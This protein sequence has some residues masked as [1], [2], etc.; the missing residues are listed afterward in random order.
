MTIHRDTRTVPYTADQMFELVAGIDD[1]PDFIPWCVGMK[2]RSRRVDAEGSG[3]ILA[4]MIVGY[5][6]FR[7]RFRSK[8]R[9]DRAAKT[10]VVDYV[11]GPFRRLENRWT[12]TDLEGGGSEID[13]VIDFEFKSRL[14]QATANQVLDKAFKRLSDAFLARAKDLH[15]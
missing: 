2:V 1:Y 12:F 5:K 15:G 14:L 8:V 11:N 7:E 10:I 6:V 3:E 13:F 9:L 4:D